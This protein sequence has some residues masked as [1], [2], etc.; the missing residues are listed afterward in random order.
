MQNVKNV[1]III[2]ATCVLCIITMK[3]E[4][5]STFVLVSVRWQKY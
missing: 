3:M 4:I 1:T 2:F 5:C